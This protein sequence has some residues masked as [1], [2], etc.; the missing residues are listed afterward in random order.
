MFEGSFRKD[1]K[2]ST[3]R[4][5]SD[6]HRLQAQPSW[7]SQKT[8]WMEWCK[9]HTA[10]ESRRKQTSHEACSSCLHSSFN[11]NRKRFHDI[12]ARA[13]A[14][15]ELQ[16]HRMEKRW[17]WKKQH[18]KRLRRRVPPAKDLQ[19]VSAGLPAWVAGPEDRRTDILCNRR[20]PTNWYQGSACLHSFRSKRRVDVSFQ[21]DPKSSTQRRGSDL[22]RLQAQ[23]SWTSQKMN[24]DG[25]TATESRR[26]QTSHEACSSCPHSSFNSNRKRF[27]DITARARVRRPLQQHKME[28]R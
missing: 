27:Y 25:I 14:R 11:S 20:K 2:S 6:L 28:K 19:Y 4:R 12:T 7:T 15:R 5:G 23:P 13:R 16:Q 1:P 8:I 18:S 21:K 3:Q 9:S 24:S 22:H 10:T 17:R 26:K